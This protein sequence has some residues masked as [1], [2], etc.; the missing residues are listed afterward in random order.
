MKHK[1]AQ[2]LTGE[3]CTRCCVGRLAAKRGREYVRHKEELVIIE[4]VPAWVC[5]KCGERRQAFVAAGL[6]DPTAY[7]SADVRPGTQHC[8][9]AALQANGDQRL[10]QPAGEKRTINHG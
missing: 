1:K 7:M 5:N 9:S 4:N 3:I 6:A 10:C 8:T 2:D